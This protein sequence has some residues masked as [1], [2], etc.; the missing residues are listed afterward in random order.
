[1]KKKRLM[2]GSTKDIA[3]SLRKATRIFEAQP[4][5]QIPTSSIFIVSSRDCLI[6]NYSLPHTDFATIPHHVILQVIWTDR[7]TDHNLFCI[8]VGVCRKVNDIASYMLHV[9]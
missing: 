1:M 4:L 7:Q 3:E 9:S 6:N 8:P 2:L 5:C